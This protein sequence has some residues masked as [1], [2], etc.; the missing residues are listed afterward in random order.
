MWVILPIDYRSPRSAGGGGSDS[1]RLHEL[2]NQEV[3][4]E[5]LRDCGEEEGHD[6][7]WSVA[8]LHITGAARVTLICWEHGNNLV[9]SV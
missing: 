7:R 9:P 8:T 1:L 5:S 2:Q 4:R 3:A 6:G